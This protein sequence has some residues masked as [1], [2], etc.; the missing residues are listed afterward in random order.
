[1]A[2]AAFELGSAAVDPSPCTHRWVHL[3]PDPS[4]VMEVAVCMPGHVVE[5]FTKV[6]ILL[7][8]SLVW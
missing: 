8:V 3:L 2:V 6:Y 4:P 1:M 5:L 7:S